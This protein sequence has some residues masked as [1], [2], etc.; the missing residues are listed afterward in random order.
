MD[1]IGL[2]GQLKSRNFQG[3]ELMSGAAVN[4]W[5]YDSLAQE[6][7]YRSSATGGSLVPFLTLWLLL[8]PPYQPLRTESAFTHNDDSHLPG[9]GHAEEWK[10]AMGSSRSADLREKAGRSERAALGHAQ[11]QHPRLPLSGFSA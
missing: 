3:K 11:G 7:I 10:L 4:T 8:P 1:W 2:T 6:N 5:E 9:S